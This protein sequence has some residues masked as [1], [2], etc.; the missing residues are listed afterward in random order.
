[1]QTAPI[2]LCPNMGDS[3]LMKPI[4]K[5]Y[6]AAVTEAGGVWRELPFGVDEETLRREVAACGGVLFSGGEDIDPARYGAEKDPR[7]GTISPQRDDLESRTMAVARELGKPMLCICRGMQLLNVVEGGTLFQDIVDRQ[8]V[9]H[10]DPLR[11]FDIVH[12]VT[13][14][15]DTALAEILGSGRVGVNS[16]HHQAVDRIAPT[17]KAT[18]VSEDGFVEALEYREEG[19]F[20]VAVQWHPERLT[21]LAGQRGLFQALI[22]A[23]TES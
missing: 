10:M 4:K 11:K 20:C 9:K 18:A 21:H 23:A 12:Q 22:Q 7:C 19:P 6:I 3:L 5:R 1:M 16:T 15:P 14:Q 13:V 17:L 8:Q 2:I